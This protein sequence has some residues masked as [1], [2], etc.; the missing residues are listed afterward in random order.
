VAAA[1]KKKLTPHPS[2]DCM[3]RILAW[4]EFLDALEL[5]D[6]HLCNTDVDGTLELLLDVYST[7]PTIC[8]A[9]RTAA[10]NANE[11]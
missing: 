7:R 8:V 3:A 11:V 5:V 10:L 6:K 1:S 4:Y 9:C 2:C